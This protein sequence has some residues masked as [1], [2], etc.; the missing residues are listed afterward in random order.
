MNRLTRTWLTLRSSLWFVPSLLVLAGVLLALA[1]IRLDLYLPGQA[2]EGYA[3]LLTTSPEGARAMLQAIAGSMVTVAGV[4]FSITI[5]TLSLASS[6]YS[7]RVLR[8]FMKDPTNQLVLGVFVGI[9]AYCIVVL[10][11]I[12]TDVLTFVPSI[13]VLVGGVLSLV[14]I[15]FLI[16]FIHHTAVSIQASNIVAGLAA[17][18]L[19]AVGRPYREAPESSA[20]SGPGADSADEARGTW[21][22]V[23]APAN[24]YVQRLEHRA[25]IEIAERERVVVRAERRVGEFVSEGEALLAV[26]G[27]PEVVARLGSKLADAYAIG[28]QRTVEQDPAWGLRQIADVAARALSPGIN[29]TTTAVTCLHYLTAILRHLAQRPPPAAR[30]RSEGR[31]RLVAPVATHAELASIA[32]DDLRVGARGNPTMLAA[33]LDAVDRLAG[34][35]TEAGRLDLGRHLRDLRQTIEHTLEIPAER[36]ALLQ[37]AAS[38]AQRLDG[39]AVAPPSRASSQ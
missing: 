23:P 13:A 34:S 20:A 35:R 6:Q 38:L 26:S 22:V 2:T 32:L 36:E 1:L 10:G 27:P 15:G 28:R 9:F 8:G 12:R 3:R 5:V 4:V 7:P 21:Q 17:E 30:H 14:G 18:A 25:L 31:L 37:A 16:R 11:A 19:E 24:G 29:D 39:P 33:L